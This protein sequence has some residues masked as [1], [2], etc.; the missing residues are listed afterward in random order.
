VAGPHVASQ[1]SPRDTVF[2]DVRRLAGDWPE[3][4][5]V[6]AERGVLLRLA[7]FLDGEPFAIHEF[8][9]VAF[10]EEIADDVFVFVPPPGEEVRNALDVRHELRI[11]RLHEAARVAPFGVYVPAVV[12]DGWRMRVHFIAEN[13]QHGWPANVSIHYADEMASVNLNVNQQAAS[14]EALPARAPDGDDWR[15]EH[16]AIGGTRVQISTG[17]LGLD[18]IAELAATLVPAPSEPPALG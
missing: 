15:I 11:V 9:S 12:P 3:E 7:T 6:D 16:L 4:Y 14:G 17:D 13:N 2:P 18:A 1:P 10:D 5:L 8:V